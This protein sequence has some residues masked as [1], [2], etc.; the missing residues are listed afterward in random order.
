MGY[1]CVIGQ[2]NT[3]GFA[4]CSNDINI[5]ETLVRTPEGRAR[6]A[7][8]SN[9]SPSDLNTTMLLFE[10]NAAK[11]LNRGNKHGY[12]VARA[13]AKFFRDMYQERRS[14]TKTSFV[15][16]GETPV[17]GQKFDSNNMFA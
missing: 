2:V 1:D 6:L 4:D 14:E 3:D 8:Y 5:V 10:G 9:L 13:F 17:T 12:E 7:H 16:P 15:F 11:E